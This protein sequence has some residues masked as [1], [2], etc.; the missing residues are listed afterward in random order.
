MDDK[1]NLNDRKSIAYIR[2]DHALTFFKPF[3]GEHENHLFVM[4]E[5]AYGDTASGMMHKKT[6]QENYSID[7]EIITEIFK[8]LIS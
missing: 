7:E 3:S 6:I 8:R 5:D 1:I 2:E 4:Y